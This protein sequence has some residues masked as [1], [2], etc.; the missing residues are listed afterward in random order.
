[1]SYAFEL[2]GIFLVIAGCVT[3]A[4]AADEKRR[5]WRIFGLTLTGVGSVIILS[6]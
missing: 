6:F 1:M 2:L 5:A 3:S 4:V